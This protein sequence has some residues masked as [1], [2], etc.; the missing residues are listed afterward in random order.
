MRYTGPGFLLK[1]SDKKWEEVKFP[2]A[3]LALRL[4]NVNGFIP[5]LNL[6]STDSQGLS[7]QEYM[8][9]S[10]IV[11]RQKTRGYE[12]ISQG[13]TTWS[14]LPAFEKVYRSPHPVMQCMTKKRQISTLRGHMVY[15]L[16][17]SAK[18]DEYESLSK[19]FDEIIDSFEW[20]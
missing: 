8:R 13:E 5:N 11:Q 9:Q 15:V 4:R 2:P 12:R 10:E 20:L 3:L 18:E 1:Y 14:G 6:L 17:C 7:P 19:E 16:T